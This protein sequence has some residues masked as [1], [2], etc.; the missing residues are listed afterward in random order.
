MVAYHSPVKLFSAGLNDTPAGQFLC[1]AALA[2]SVARAPA[3]THPIVVDL[4]GVR[5]AAGKCHLEMRGHECWAVRIVFNDFGNEYVRV[6]G[7]FYLAPA[8]GY[9]PATREIY[10][11]PYLT[12]AGRLV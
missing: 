2:A 3:E 12:A 4:E 1:G 11:V 8:V 5:R 6:R 9:D 7:G 10:A